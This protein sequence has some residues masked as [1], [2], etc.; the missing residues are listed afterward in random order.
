MTKDDDIFKGKSFADLLKDIYENSRK[1]DRQIKLLIAQLEPLVKNLN[2]ASVVVP[3]IKEYL[4][5]SVKNDDQLVRMAAIAQR[6]LNAASG[7][8]GGFAL[9]DEE[10]RQLIEASKDVDTK[11]TSLKKDEE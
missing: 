10:K 6:L 1:K 7:D 3:L 5:V 2:D 11:L 4:E 8:T 9:T